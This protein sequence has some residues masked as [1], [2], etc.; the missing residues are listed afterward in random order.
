LNTNLATSFRLLLVGHGYFLVNDFYVY[1]RLLIFVAVSVIELVF[2]Q[3]C[4]IWFREF[5][6]LVTLKVWWSIW[7]LLTCHRLLTFVYKN[8]QFVPI[9]SK[10]IPQ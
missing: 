7:H 4:F 2:V 9:Y 5:V 1:Q 6:Q 8:R 10:V 3:Q